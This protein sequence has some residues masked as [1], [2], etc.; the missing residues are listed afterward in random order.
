MDRG[1]KKLPG[2]FTVLMPPKKND[3]PG[4]VK[5]RRRAV[6]DG[7]VQERIN[8]WTKLKCVQPSGGSLSANEN[9]RGIKRGLGDQI[10]GP[11]D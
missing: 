3:S 7:F 11:V 8:F 1:R 6:P 10:G 2:T 4:W 9:E 5:R